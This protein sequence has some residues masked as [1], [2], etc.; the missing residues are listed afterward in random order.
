MMWPFDQGATCPATSSGCGSVWRA[1][2]NT[3]DDAQEW[4]INYSDDQIP[5]GGGVPIM[6]FMTATQPGGPWTG[7]GAAHKTAGWGPGHVPPRPQDGKGLYKG[8]FNC[9]EP[10]IPALESPRGA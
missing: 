5:K 6:R 4:V 3:S 10:P 9:S 2:G 1:V 7:V 8:C